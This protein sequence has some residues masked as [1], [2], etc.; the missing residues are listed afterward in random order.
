MAGWRTTGH[1]PLVGS[2]PHRWT[3]WR[4]QQRAQK[5]T[6]GREG[7]D[8]RLREYLRAPDTCSISQLRDAVQ[9]AGGIVPERVVRP[10]LDSVAVDIRAC[11][12]LRR[13]VRVAQTLLGAGFIFVFRF[14]R[15]RLAY[16]KPHRALK[17]ALR[18]RKRKRLLDMLQQAELAAARQDVRGLY[19]VVN[20]LC[21]NKHKQR[22]R[23]RDKEGQLM[24]GLQECQAMAEYARELFMA[25]NSS[26][27]PL[28]KVSLDVLCLERWQRAAKQLKA[29]KA[30]PHGTPPL[31]NWKQHSETIVPLLHQTA[32]HA[33]CR[34]NPCIP[35]EWTEVQLAWL[36]KPKKC[37]NTPANLRTVGL[38]AGDT[39]LFM[40]VLKE[41]VHGFVMSGSYR[42]SA[43]CAQTALE[44]H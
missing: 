9:Q 38:M 13:R 22:I 27:Y 7:D 28:L 41:A 43:I 5:H 11:W 8:S 20:L 24:S 18:A 10:D 4:P 15:L 2:I 25:P 3:P 33:L 21:P 39:K 16:L 14:F 30:A 31:R 35:T 23:L 26:P 29:E 44:H 42:C 19:G 1:G 40:S 32:V 17:K 34:E 6:A 36:A 12:E 37:P